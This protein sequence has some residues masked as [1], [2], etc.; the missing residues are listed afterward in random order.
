MSFTGNENDYYFQ[1]YPHE[2]LI[3]SNM[4]DFEKALSKQLC[5]I[6]DHS[7]DTVGKLDWFQKDIYLFK[8]LVITSVVLNILMFLFITIYIFN[9]LRKNQNINIK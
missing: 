3:V 7:Y 2:S 5:I 1:C 9:N 6:S 4:T 8:G